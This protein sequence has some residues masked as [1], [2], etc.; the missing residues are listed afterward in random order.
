MT[1][2]AWSA[3]SDHATSI[4]RSSL[5]PPASHRPYRSGLRAYSGN[6]TKLYCCKMVAQRD[7]VRPRLNQA[8]SLPR[9]PLML[10]IRD[11]GGG[12]QRVVCSTVTRHMAY[13]MPLRQCWLAAGRL[14]KQPGLEQ[15]TTPGS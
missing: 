9:A 1:A 12:V 5:T 3:N 2:K 10:S 4:T 15:E 13:G 14:T 6:S 8:T 11:I 7:R